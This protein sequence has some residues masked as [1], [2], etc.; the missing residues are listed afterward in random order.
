MMTNRSRVAPGIPTGGQFA[1]ETRSES[2]ISLSSPAPTK[3]WGETTVSEGSRTPWGPADQVEHVADGIAFVHTSSHG[4]V[5]LS[6][7]RNREIPAALRQRSGWYEEDA[8]QSVVGMY[9]PEEMRPQV[10]RG[11]GADRGV[12]EWRELS[13]VSVRDNFPDAYEK[14][15]G[16]EV[17]PGEST[18]RDAA[19]WRKAHEDDWVLRSAMGK[20][21]EVE[22][23]AHRRGETKNFMITRAEYEARLS[24]SDKGPYG[25]F[26]LDLANARE[27]P[28]EPEA[29]KTPATQY[30]GVDTSGL[31]ELQRARTTEELAKRWRDED[32]RVR[33]M[34]QIIAEDGI[35]EKKVYVTNGKREYFLTRRD[36]VEDRASSAFPV[37]KALWEAVEAPDTRTP[38]Q[39]ASEK[40]SVAYHRFEHA[41]GSERR[42]AQTA[43]N[44]A[45]TEENQLRDAEK[46]VQA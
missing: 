16:L 39:L 4:G 13:T 23:T 42:A 26:A 44:A 7:E 27:L 6:A 33:T 43:Y 14:A 46:S 40:T 22:V 35:T 41:Y 20:G 10:S 9:F 29:P 5:K 24:A 12:D 15:T 31:T 2:G 32:N 21:D 18:V 3:N 28:K 17:Q 34:A 36:N 37:S 8:E 25:I 30:K 19:L 45:R 38:V 1:H 11:F